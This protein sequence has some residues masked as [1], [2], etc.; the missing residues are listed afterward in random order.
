MEINSAEIPVKLKPEIRNGGH[1]F[2]LDLVSDTLGEEID[3]AC[4]IPKK[5]FSKMMV[6]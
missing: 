6:K 2:K 5:A 1:L 4:E 3:D